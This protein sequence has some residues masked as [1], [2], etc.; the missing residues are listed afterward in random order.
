MKKLLA[1]A[2]I[3]FAFTACKKKDTDQHCWKCENSKSITNDDGTTTTT[4]EIEDKCG[5]TAEEI[6]VYERRYR[7]RKM[8]EV[9][10]GNKV[11]TQVEDTTGQ[12]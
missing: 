1:I 6:H 5:M 12:K 8:L 7:A 4:L 10:Y 11:C 3:A 9:T 2:L